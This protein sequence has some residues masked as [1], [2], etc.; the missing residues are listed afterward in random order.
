MRNLLVAFCSLSGLVWADPLVVHEWGTFTSLQDE[1]GRCLGGIN[2]D[3]EPV[4]E[5]V[6]DLG[7][8][9]VDAT[10]QALPSKGLQPHLASVTLRLETPVL[11]FHLPASQKSAQV[12][13][14]VGF[15]GGWLSQFY[16]DAKAEAPGVENSRKQGPSATTLGRLQWLG[17]Q[18]GGYHSGPPSQSTVWKAPRQAKSSPVTTAKGEKEQFLF[19]RGVGHVDSPIRVKSQFA[20]GYIKANSEAGAIAR[21]WLVQVGSNGSLAFVNQGPFEKTAKIALPT[22]KGKLSDLRASMKAALIQDG[23]YGDEAQAMLDAWQE[24]YFKAPGLRL[25]Y[26]VPKPWTDQVLPLTVRSPLEVKTQRVMI[27]R[28]ELVTPKQRRDLQACRQGEGAAYQRLGR[29]RQ[30]LLRLP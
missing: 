19:Y 6:H 22:A 8:L 18:V 1:N 12:D 13:V 24:S 11:Y 27:G 10:P 28:V 9:I 20:A 25:F 23:L 17:L 3:D 30:A 29:F 16:P 2:V 4:P 21:A 14:E 15:Q 26:I 5:F 7:N